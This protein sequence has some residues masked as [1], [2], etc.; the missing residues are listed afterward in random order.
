MPL[1]LVASLQGGCRLVRVETL[2][3]IVLGSSRA[4]FGPTLLEPCVC[5]CQSMLARVSRGPGTRFGMRAHVS[6]AKKPYTLLQFI[7]CV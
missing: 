5:S 6:V 1:C 7:A 3:T 2:A 4:W